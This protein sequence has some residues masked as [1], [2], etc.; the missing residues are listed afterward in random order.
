M[1]TP[2]LPAARP[3]HLR[4]ALEVRFGARVAAHLDE[5]AAALPPDIVTRLGRARQA[6]LLHVRHQRQTVA[7]TVVV[8]PGAAAGRAPQTQPRWQRALAW[9]PLLAMVLGVWAI[10]EYQ[11]QRRV[12]AAAEIDARLLTDVLPP[13]AYADPGF[14]QFLSE[15]GQR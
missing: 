6:A 13:A 7:D 1:T 5:A 14:V 10:G 3:P 8:A 15:G 11:A 9:M 12:R 2:Q 4:D